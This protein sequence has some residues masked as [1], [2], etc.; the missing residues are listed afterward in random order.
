MLRIRAGDLFCP[1]TTMYRTCPSATW[2][3]YPLV[4][5]AVAL[6][7]VVV[8]VVVA[9]S[10]LSY[11]FWTNKY[12]TFPSWELLLTSPSLGKPSFTL[13]LVIFHPHVTGG[14]NIP[15]WNYCVRL[16]F[17]NVQH[18]LQRWSLIKHYPKE[19]KPSLFVLFI[20]GRQTNKRGKTW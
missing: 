10:S 11:H 17:D 3:A 6:L 8:V 12:P 16:P 19:E 20:A 15:S 7:I 13:L 14:N 5:T 1:P 4:S 9:L 2:I 18:K